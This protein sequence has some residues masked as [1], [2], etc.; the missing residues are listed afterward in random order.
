MGS[1]LQPFYPRE[2]SRRYTVNRRLTWTP[3]PLYTLRKRG[4]SLAPTGNR[5]MI[6][7]SSSLHPTDN[8]D[9][10]NLAYTDRT[11]AAKNK[12]KHVASC[13][14]DNL[15]GVNLRHSIYSGLRV[16]LTQ[17]WNR[18]FPFLDSSSWK[19]V[20][21]EG[22]AFCSSAIRRLNISAVFLKDGGKNVL[23]IHFVAQRSVI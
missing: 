5:P 10:A 4:K 18:S 16:L 3:K 13:C 9:C 15:N 20:W 19:N 11:V 17:A 6:P 7:Q 23:D 8:T 21:G 14:F 2:S 22:D 12:T 1:M